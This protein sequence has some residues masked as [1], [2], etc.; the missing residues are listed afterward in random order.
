M[1]KALYRKA[2]EILF[3]ISFLLPVFAATESVGQNKLPE[4]TISINEEGISLADLLNQISQKGGVAFSYNP[5]RIQADR[6]VS[7]HAT[8]KTLASVL[9]E[10]AARFGLAFEFVEN[11]VIIKPKKASAKAESQPVTLSGIIRDS[12]T[13]EALIGA[14]VRVIELQTG[15]ISNAFGFYSVTIPPGHYTIV[16]SFI[17]YAEISRT[18]DLE[19]AARTDV[20]LAEQPPVLDEVVVTSISSITDQILTS[21]NTVRPATVEERPE[22]FGEQDV[23]KSLESLPGVKFHSDGSTFYYVRGGQ[24]DQNLVFIDD[25]PIYSPSHMLGIF[26]TIIPDAVND[27]TLY[28]GDM[29]ASLG[30]RLSSVLDVR[31]KKGND[32]HFSAWGNV[33]L[34]STK[35]G[36]E[37]PF[38][39]GASSYL[40]SSRTSSLKWFLRR[41]DANI[42]QFNFYDLTGKVN[43]RLNQNNRIFFSFYS[44]ADNYFISDKGI[45]WSN[46]AG[47][48]QWN[49]LFNDRLFLNT[50]IAGGEYDYFLHTDVTKGQKWNSHISNFNIK[51]DF[52][53]FVRPDNEITFGAGLN[54]YTFNPGNFYVGNNISALPVVSVRNSLEGIL[55]GNHEVRLN[56]KFGIRYGIRLSSWADSGEAFEFIFE[57]GNP[58]DTLTFQKGIVYKRFLN[59]EPRITLSFFPNDR[60]SLK[61]SFSRNV[62]NIHLISNSISPFTSLE[63]WLPSSFNIKPQSAKQATIGYYQDSFLN[64]FSFSVEGFYKKMFNQIDYESHAQTLLN[65][66]LESEL[67][68]GKARAYGVE[69]LVKKEQGRLHGWVGYTWSRAK[70][71]FPEING[72]REYNAFYDRPHQISLLASYNVSSRWQVSANW[73]YSTGSAYSSP[74]SF[75]SFNGEEVPVYGQKNNDRLPDYHRLDLS[76]NYRLNRNPANRFVHNLSFS[77]FNFYGRKNPLFINYNKVEAEDGSLKVPGTADDPNKV[78]SQFYLYGFMPS[79]SYNFKWL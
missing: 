29:P 6:Q 5:R 18:V 75:Y 66:L 31:T 56:E 17:G 58:V 36:I 64:S 24:R 51:T 34:L 43:F 45:A 11:Q 15:A 61:A 73:S 30:G 22:M 25:A 53:Y 2:R 59:A 78:I 3:L 14:T 28:K 52:S 42:Q 62:Q 63:V 72:G 10:M 69:L 35:V 20:M 47:T 70:R 19:Q 48:M 79:V 49:H 54:G 67:R 23:I 41:A 57:N 32:Q 40:L 71:K 60:S 4:V 13:G 9:D 65:P 39:K 33:G 50:T 46:N 26:S 38:K 68:F 27:I 55:Y 76:A 74:V 21:S 1:L 44:G 8:N 12:N 16:Y 37:G 7:Y 77:V